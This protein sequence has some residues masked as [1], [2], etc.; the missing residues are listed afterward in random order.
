M[1]PEGAF[2]KAMVID[3][4]IK[5]APCILP[6]LKNRPLTLKRYPVLSAILKFRYK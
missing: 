3:Y 6:H 5:A 2:T 4:Y 1:Y